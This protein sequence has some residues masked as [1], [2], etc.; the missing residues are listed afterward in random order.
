MT[1]RGVTLWRDNRIDGEWET[2]VAE[3][4]IGFRAWFVAEGDPV[5]RLERLVGD[6]IGS[7]GALSSVWDVEGDRALIDDVVEAYLGLVRGEGS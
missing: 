4:A 5:M 6:Y 1:G 7:S 2:T 3:I